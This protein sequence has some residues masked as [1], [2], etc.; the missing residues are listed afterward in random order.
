M[1]RLRELL[2]KAHVIA[3]IAFA[4]RIGFFLFQVHSRPASMGHGVLGGFETVQIATSLATGKGFSSPIGVASGPTAWLTPIFPG[5]L[6]G[7]FKIFGVGSFGAETAIKFLDCLFSSLVCFPLV[8]LGRRLAISSAGV[9]GAWIWALLPS[10]ILF[11]AVWVWDT[12]LT[13]LCLTLLLYFAYG[14]AA[15]SDWRAWAAYGALCAFSALTNAALLS[16]VLGFAFFGVYRARSRTAAWLRNASVAAAIFLA[17]IAPWIVRN[18]IVF[19]GQVAFRSNLGLELWLGNNPEVADLW[20]PWLHPSNKP[21][22]KQRFLLLGEPAYMREKQRLALQ[23]IASHP[24]DTLVFS[25]RRFMTTWTGGD[26]Y[27]NDLW[28]PLPWGLRLDMLLNCSFSMLA[29][30]G[31]L[32]LARTRA[33][34][35]FPFVWLLLSF[36]MIYYLTHSSPRYRAPL[37]P[38]LALLA[39]YAVVEGSRW[40]RERMGASGRYTDAAV[41]IEEA[42]V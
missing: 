5:L 12:S 30:A 15:S 7:L 28:Q 22:E 2:S 23:F 25:Y 34:D 3:L 20:A 14:V 8:A 9:F 4:L 17:G 37:D 1:L 38:S 36:P 16:A 11:A 42:R 39:A 10:S 29:F 31:L 27:L 6:A 18:E 21:E 35:V 26:N 33:A 32:R 40:L 41:K 13:A 24:A 19:R